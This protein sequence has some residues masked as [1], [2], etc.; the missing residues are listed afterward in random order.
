[1]AEV[2]ADEMEEVALP[3]AGGGGLEIREQLRR[4]SSAVRGSGS[5]Q[6]K[7]IIRR[8]EQSDCVSLSKSLN[9]QNSRL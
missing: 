9:P 4:E 5:R 7:S 1:M 3:A 2:G 6:E 8:K